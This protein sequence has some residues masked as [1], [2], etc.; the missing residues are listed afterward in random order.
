MKTNK[1]KN[2]FHMKYKLTK[3]KDDKFNGK[4]PNFIDEGYWETGHQI[5]E[6]EV[7]ERFL[8]QGWGRYLKTSVVTEIL[9]ETEE[10]VIFKTVNSTY[11]LE[12]TDENIGS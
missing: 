5:S 2:N 6:L 12:L 7:G 8:I 9:E 10:Y 3:L 11:R 4:H 1:I